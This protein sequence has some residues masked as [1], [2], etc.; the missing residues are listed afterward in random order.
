MKNKL[1]SGFA[2][3]NDYDFPWWKKAFKELEK[4]QNDFLSTNPHP[5]DYH[6]PI[7]AL[8]NFIR[9][10]EYPY[11]YQ[12]IL[13]IFPKNK[14]L[15]ILDVGSGITFFPY[16][17][18]KLSHQVTALD[19]DKKTLTGLEIA[20]KSI[21]SQY[22]KLNVV[23]EDAKKMSFKSGTFDLVYSI[24]VLEHIPSNQLVIKELSRVLKKD[25]FCILTFDVN[26]NENE[27]GLNPEKFKKLR[28]EIDNHF[29][30]YYLE[31][32]VHPLDLVSTKNSKYPLKE[33]SIAMFYLKNLKKVLLNK[34]KKYDITTMGMV[35][36]KK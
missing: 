36:Q 4:A 10:W 24:S 34:N 9:S 27:I 22:K 32:I 25:G 8:H 2:D 20:N 28:Q 17:L 16:A 5:S 3:I 11:V 29:N 19:N 33:N 14:K 12:N 18:S 6:W 1:F 21:K 23:I 30:F 35:L 13:N 31:R 26:L 15:N 7:D